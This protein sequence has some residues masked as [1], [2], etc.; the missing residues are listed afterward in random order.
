M[1]SDLRYALR[2]LAKSPGFTVTA[3][4][5]LTLGIG[6]NTSIFSLVHALVF[7]PRPWPR[8][9]EV[10]QLYSQNEKNR[11]E[12][13]L[14]SYPVYREIL[15]RND[16][17]AG[18][19]AHSVGLVGVGE[20]ENTRRLFSAF[21]SANFFSTLQVPL[22]RGRG[23]TPGE[24]RPGAALPSV[25]VSYNFWK[26]HGLAPDFVG[27]TIRVNERLFT[28]VGIAPEGFSGTLMLLGPELYFPLGVLDLLSNDYQTGDRR[29]LD[30]PGVTKLHLAARLKPGLPPATAEAALP[31]LAKSIRAFHPDALRE[32]TFTARPLP[33]LNVSN[34]PSDEGPLAVLG[35]TL[36]AMVAIV[37]LIACLNLA[38]LL[39]AR[40]ETRRK[41]FAI[42][43][44]LGGSRFRLVRL[45][46][47][48]GFLLAL[49]GGAAGF[50]LGVWP[51]E[52][53]VGAMG[54]VA[55][56]GFFYHGSTSPALFAATFGFCTLAT[57][58]FALGP[59]LKFSR[60]D[61][62]YGLKE[63]SAENPAG[64]RRRW[65]RL[66]RHPLLA[67]QIALSLALLT[68]G[69][70]FIRGA[71]KAGSIETGFR[72]DDTL[73]IEVD[74]SLGGYGQAHSLG[75]YR[76]IGARLAALPGVQHASIGAVAPFGMV[77][78][79]RPV[80]RAGLKPA[81]NAKPATAAEGL[82][83]NTR[84][85]SI[86]ANYFAALGLPVLR[87]R[88]FTPSECEAAGAPA[89]AIIDEVLARRL[90]P[91]GNPLGQRIQ[92]AE[93]GAQRSAEG[94]SA[95]N[96]G[97]SSNQARTATDATS[98][99]IVG[100][101]PA[102]RWELAGRADSGVIYVPFAQGFQSN[103]FFHLRTAARAPGA[104]EALL[105]TV[106][107]AVRDA[108]PGVPVFGVKTFR[109]H[110]DANPQLWMVRGGAGLFTLFGVLA[111][112][113]SVVGIYGVHAYSVARRTR[114]I[115]IRVALGA[116]PGAVQRMMLREGL[117]LTLTGTAFGLLLSLALGRVISNLLY[118]VSPVDPL[119][120]SLAPVVLATA[121]LL[122]AWL[123]ARRAA[124]VDPM[125]ALRAE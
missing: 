52:A 81:P 109:Q 45:L 85:N 95:G 118:E 30:Q 93:A 21:V 36:L 110:L 31:A 55:P 66:P 120:F 35:L 88:A 116:A 58:F 28:V 37:L 39:L 32:Q 77:T 79:D 73:L 99:E 7:S 94:G 87:G 119:A 40:G 84:W 5:V 23:F 104:D 9:Q 33:R 41:E 67:A 107:Q 105:A 100:I 82:A 112:A 26:R 61:V 121:A 10:V 16:L 108:A 6:V 71:L 42:R 20:G 63:V 22:L 53:L 101:V 34:A 75:L 123:P 122:A 51:L 114:E 57:L 90:F 25:V 68:S 92:W 54:T 80:Q 11:G 76:A 60:V 106:R 18:V 8:A 103:A 19:L 97:A 86:G 89:V 47:L 59:A 13:R 24:E 102:T 48:E 124:R 44:A 29:G 1:L 2:T 3:V 64:V 113:L 38:S 17:F 27:R 46:L 111:L 91:E 115:G 49:A 98:L 70:L 65:R 125:V 15:Q 4:L 74:A 78:I 62:F 69:T 50:F 14:F 43:L 56:I 12:F 83:F 117:V 96:L 72:A